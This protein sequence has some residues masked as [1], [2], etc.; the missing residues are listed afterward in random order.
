MVT[1]TADQTTI[2]APRRR[3]SRR[4]PPADR[5]TFPLLV[6]AVHW[7]VAQVPA[8][9][10]FLYGTIRP[11]AP[12]TRSGESWAYGDPLGSMSGLA[13]WLVEPMRQWDG[14]WYRLVAV[15]GYEP[16][17]SFPAKAAFWPLY[18]WLMD[19]GSS[20]TGISPESVGYIISNVAFAGALVL[21]YHLVTFDF[22]V[23]VAR[24]TLWALALFPTAFFFNAV[25]TESLFLLFTVA[26]LLAA[27]AR[28]WW[29]AGILGLLAALTRSAGVMLL[30][31]MGILFLQ[32]YG[33]NIRRWFPSI[34]PAALP[35][36]GPLIFGWRLTTSGM[37]FL[38]WIN[39]QWQWN[40]FRA[41]P[42]ETFECATVGC[43]AEVPNLGAFE[44]RGVD[45][46]WVE[47]LLASPTWRTITS[48][49]F[50]DAFARG[51]WLEL[52]VTIGAFALL[53]IGV[54]RVPLYY[55]ALVLPPLIVPLFSPS[56]VHPL[57]SM[58]RFVLPMFPLFVII[59]LLV[60]NRAVGITLGVLSTVLM[61]ALSAQFATWYWVS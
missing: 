50:R 39:V 18:P 13:H 6:F 5:W 9:L 31:P 33:S 15:S 27:R 29:L 20:L 30:A 37:Q 1:E 49:E 43:L 44:A 56:S 41:M 46:S 4:R 21:L 45:W 7:V 26:T 8:T 53:L 51:D 36:L 17:G 42:W 35:A 23:P 19:L 48:Y 52:L 25:Y 16:M 14:T 38:D 10:T 54:R 3:Y 55:F 47:M 12:G 24:R 22:D 57:M 32:Q 2:S 60:S 28:N 59:A 34:F 11:S 61:M 58:P 40:R